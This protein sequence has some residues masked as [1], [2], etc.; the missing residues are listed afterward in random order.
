MNHQVP[1]FQQ[2]LQGNLLSRA[3]LLFFIREFFRECQIKPGLFIEFGVLN[4]DSIKQAFQILRG[5][6]EDFIG[7]DTFEGI[8]ILSDFDKQCNMLHPR[9]IEG[10][11]KSM[12]MK[13]VQDALISSGIKS[14]HL[15][16]YKKDIRQ[17]GKHELESILKEFNLLPRIIHLDV[18]L[19]S[20]TLAA[21]KLITPLVPS[22]S[23]FLF[24]DFY[25]Y[26]GSPFCGVQ[27]AI[28]DYCAE[29]LNV[30]FVP[31]SNY[32]GWGKAFIFH[33][34]P[35]RATINDTGKQELCKRL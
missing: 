8:P 10:N 20:S 27:K 14:E 21:L 29:N 12:D 25:C 28:S 16:L 7:F 19:H 35:D 6:I 26:Q 2:S 30:K 33:V 32:N 34:S 9:F 11:Y 1:A 3:N 23:W 22:G 17:I 31:Y 18:D 24:D 4:G 5:Y 15:R 13:L